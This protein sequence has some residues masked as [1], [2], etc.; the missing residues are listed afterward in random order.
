M[1]ATLALLRKEY[2]SVESFVRDRCGLTQEEVEQIRRN[3]I[4]E[5]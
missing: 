2:G 3:L 5:T 1:L 4:M